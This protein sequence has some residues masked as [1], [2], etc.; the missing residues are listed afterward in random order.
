MTAIIQNLKKVNLAI[1]AGSEAGQYGLTAAP[2]VFEFI[3]GIGADG[4]EPFEV[5]LSAKSPGENLLLTL[6]ADEVPQFFGRFLGPIR[7][8]LGLHL[9]PPTLCLQII[10]KSVVDADNREVVKALAKSTGHSGCGG[11]CDCGCGSL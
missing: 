7:H 3:F 9:F 2:V 10:V 5:A 6:T 1:L 8:L 11:S 4:L